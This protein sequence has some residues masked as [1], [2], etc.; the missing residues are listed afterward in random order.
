[1]P[2]MTPLVELAPP[3]LSPY[4]AG[5]TGLD[6]VWSFAA[7]KPGP[8]VFLTALTHGNEICGAIALDRLLRAEL[9]PAI[10]K[11]TFAFANIA[12]YEG[13]DTKDPSAA[14]YIDEDMNRVWDEKLLDGPRKSREL[15]R[16]RALRPLIDTADFLL[17]IHSKIGRAHV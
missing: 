6:Y 15:Q 1:M 11:L 2:Y 7:E 16:A 8:H 4:R 13:F 9:R 12:A 5:N 3:D 10:G 14:R 17:D